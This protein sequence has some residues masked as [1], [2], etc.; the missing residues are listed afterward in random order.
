MESVILFSAVV[1]LTVALT[2][3][4]L[5]WVFVRTFFGM[6]LLGLA[7]LLYYVTCVII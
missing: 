4:G 3:I 7:T 1:S 5:A 6:S 2:A